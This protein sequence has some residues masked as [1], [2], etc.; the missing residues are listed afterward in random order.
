MIAYLLITELL[1][2]I[3][4]M[5]YLPGTGLFVE[6]NLIRDAM[7]IALMVSLLLYIAGKGRIFA[8]HYRKDKVVKG[9]CA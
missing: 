5:D 3:M 8:H 7:M 4:M 2:A 9:G 6:E 1:A